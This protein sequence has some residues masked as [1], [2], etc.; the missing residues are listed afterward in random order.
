MDGYDGEAIGL[1]AEG[2]TASNPKWEAIRTNM[3]YARNYALRMDLG[4]AVPHGDKVTQYNGSFA[5][6]GYCLAKPGS[7]YLVYLPG[8]GGSVTLDLSEV[9]GSLSVEWLDPATGVATQAGTVAGGPSVTLT[10][11]FGGAAVLFLH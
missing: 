4:A 7:Q 3:G 11:P 6:T 2:Y 5:S 10:A 9:T 8:S 1:G